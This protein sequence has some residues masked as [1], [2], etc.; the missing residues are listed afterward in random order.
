[1]KWGMKKNNT[2]DDWRIIATRVKDR[3]KNGLESE[4]KIR[5]E[6]I[7]ISKIKKQISRYGYLV[8]PYQPPIQSKYL[9][10]KRLIVD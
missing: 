10:T 4:V 5:G 8:K 2:K 1:M 7:P 3:K 6:V 9:A